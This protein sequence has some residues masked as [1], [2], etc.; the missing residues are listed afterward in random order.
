[1]NNLTD[2]I[3][4]VLNHIDELRTKFLPLSE[5][6][7]R[8]NQKVSLITK[9]INEI[10]TEITEIQTISNGSIDVFDSILN[11]LNE[12]KTESRQIHHSIEE[13]ELLRNSMTSMFG[14]AF[15]VISKFINTAKHIGIIDNNHA[16]QILEG[17]ITDIVTEIPIPE[18]INSTL[19]STLNSNIISN[20]IES[21]DPN[22]SQTSLPKNSENIGENIVENTTENISEN[23]S[24]ETSEETK[25]E[26]TPEP[27]NLSNGN[28]T[29]T[30]IATQLDLQP[31]QFNS[32]TNEP[33]NEL[34]NSQ[35]NIISQNHESATDAEDSLE[36]ILDDISKPLSTV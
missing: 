15:N 23:T 14:E 33:L 24:E 29:A 3:T 28:L 21:T 2:K 5:R 19:N 13:N 12:T 30:E 7:D 9:S 25:S 10:T 11:I 4:T 27:D 16:D 32:G 31:L 26:I 35:D 34:V 20:E 1:M 8:L 18:I 17:K 36:A 6:I 22:S